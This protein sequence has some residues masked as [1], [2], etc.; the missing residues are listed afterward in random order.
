MDASKHAFASEQKKTTAAI[1]EANQ[2]DVART[3]LSSG[4]VTQV[5][6]VSRS[7]H[8]ACLI[9]LLEIDDGRMR[10]LLESADLAF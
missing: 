2:G 10:D 3:M 7:S 1:P 4:K 6:T 9:H 8:L 5:I